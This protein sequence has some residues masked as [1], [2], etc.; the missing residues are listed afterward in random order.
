MQESKLIPNS[1]ALQPKLHTKLIPF[2]ADHYFIS[3]C[4]VVHINIT[5][6]RQ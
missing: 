5:A 1:P 6:N 2:T 4:N 3:N